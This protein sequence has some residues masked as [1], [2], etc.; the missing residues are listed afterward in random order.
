MEEGGKVPDEGRGGAWDADAPAAANPT[1]RRPPPERP[2]AS[3]PRAAPGATGTGAGPAAPPGPRAGAGGGIPVIPDRPVPSARLLAHLQ[4]RHGLAWAGDPVDLGG[5]SS[6]NLRLRERRGDVVVRVHR[7]WVAP[8]RLTAVQAVRAALRAAGL[9]VPEPVPARDGAPWTAVGEQLVEV[10]RYLPGEAMNSWPRLLTGLRRLGRVHGVLAGLPAGPA[11]RAAPAANQLD[12]DEALPLAR[13]AAA[14]IRRWA[15]SAD[16]R[17]A[18]AATEALAEHLETA[19]RPVNGRLPR[20]LVHGDFWD[21]NVLFDADAVVAILDLD[22][23]A[24]RERIDDIALI[25][26]YTNSGRTLP[27]G[28]RPDERRRRLRA[29]VDAYDRG[30]SARLTAVER[31]ALPLALARV[32]LSYTRHLLQRG[33]EAEQRAVLTAWAGDL[34][35]SL[36]IV[37][38][39]GRWQDA[40][41]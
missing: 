7:A 1:P 23:M 40:F 29:L 19:R 2:A 39:L 41:A 8:A 6:L 28:T 12:A 20:Q 22:F 24:E 5:S 4:R 33:T 13:R 11:A 31:A 14:V 27:R 32:A 10:E 34:D 35:R 21:T 25:L 30:L 16:E 9:P 36:A 3:S 18:A 17:A 38:D 37:R 26:C 15:R